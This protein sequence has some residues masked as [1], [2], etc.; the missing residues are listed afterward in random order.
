MKAFSIDNTHREEVAQWCRDHLGAEDVR[1]WVTGGRV[2]LD[3]FSH[4]RMIQV[5]NFDVTAE[6]ES[7]VTFFML[8]YA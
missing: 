2:W 3:D 5:I 7:L 6:E 4:S 8:K 1:W